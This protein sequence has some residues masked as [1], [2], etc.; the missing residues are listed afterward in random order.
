M[1]INLGN[2]ILCTPYGATSFP[3]ELCSPY[4]SDYIG[5]I[6]CHEGYYDLSVDNT[7]YHVAKG[8]TM[9]V[10]KGVLMQIISVS[11]NLSITLLFYRSQPIRDMLGTTVVAMRTYAI[12]NPRS[13]LI[14][15]TGEEEELAHYAEIIGNSIRKASTDS[16]AYDA[17]ERQLL[18]M[19]VTYRMCSIFERI[20]PQSNQISDRKME[21]FAQLLDLVDKHFIEQRSVSFYADIM[22]LSPKYLSTLV[23]QVCGKTVQQIVFKAI[24]RRSI[25]L[26]NS[27]NMSIQQIAFSLHFPNASAFGTFFKKQMGMS[28]KKYRH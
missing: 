8:E 4:Y 23:K 28:P 2:D 17:N 18:L 25:F 16:S 12:I 13:C 1:Y 11:E 5:F 27:T 6:V 7:V 22:C 3:K 24:I 9:F 10:S 21:I 15:H 20:H 19:S 14:V 26:M